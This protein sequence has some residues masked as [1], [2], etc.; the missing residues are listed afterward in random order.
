MVEGEGTFAARQRPHILTVS[1]E[2]YFHVGAFEAT[3]R[4][5]HWER[6]ESRLER[7]LIEILE[8]L[9]RFHVKG[10]FFILGWV[11]ERQ[12]ELVEKI[13]SAG[14]EV[15]SSGYWPRGLRGMV[16][17]DLREDLRRAKEVLEAAG[18]NRIVGYRSP[19]TW[20]TKEDLWLLDVLAEEG[21][22]YDSSINPIL[23]R[24]ADDPRR[25]E[26]HKH[27]HSVSERTI[28]EFPISTASFLGMRL[29][30]SGGN[31][32]RQLPHTILRRAVA[33]WD[34]TK[35]LPLVFYCM[36]WE[37]DSEQPHIKSISTLNRI[38]HYR[39]LA[40]TRWVFEEY[41]QR[42]KFQP[43]GEYLGIP[44]HERTAPTLQRRAI[45]LT[46]PPEERASSAIA[47]PV[48]IVVPLYNEAENVSYLSKTLLDLQRRLGKKFRICLNLVDDGSS[49][50]TWSE[51]SARFAGIPDVRVLKHPQ[52]RGVAA[53]ILTGIQN[54]PTEVVCSI[55]CDCSYDPDVLEAMIPLID[56]ADLVTASPYHPHGH[57]FNVPG[58]RLFLSKTLSRLYSVFF[59]DRIY[60]Y[61]SCC[62]VYRKSAVDK[63]ELK[64]AG[65]LGVAEILIRLKLKGGRVIEYPTTLESRLFGESKM[66]LIRTIWSHLGLLSNLAFRK[67]AS[68]RPTRE[69]SP[70]KPE[71]VSTSAAPPRDGIP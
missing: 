4:R 22:A 38:R 53:A 55:D 21:Y 51:L 27:R 24:F 37:L 56:E 71:T 18:A 44:R 60:T 29:A 32:V 13:A 30:I 58:W 61:T 2:D 1:V 14:H 7:N 20:V 3:V 11:A 62:R 54:A 23:R 26:I 33:R 57:V 34:Q 45:E 25:F 63:M 50:T 42:Y 65:F 39:N 66:K 9:G 40:K 36:P 52:N 17:D 41:F 48:T 46:S 68:D 16:P 70:A 35:E 43:I 15:A 59:K 31:Y 19:R 49:D 8:L 64:H 6:F 47:Q 67:N 28:W 10:T 12:P 69:K 5:K